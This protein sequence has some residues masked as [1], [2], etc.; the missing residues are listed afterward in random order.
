[1]AA[2]L[3][4]S[5]RAQAPEIDLPRPGSVLVADVT[6][7][8]AMINGDQKR[9]LKVDERVRIGS[10]LT[11]GRRSMLTL[12]LSNGASVQLGPETEIELE[13]FG[14]A[15]FSSSVKFAE[16]KAEPT[17]SRT[18]I[19]LVRGDLTAT[20]KSLQVGKGS[21]FTLSTPAGDLR[22]GAGAFHAMV[23]MHDLGLGVA[24]LELQSGT[25]EFQVAGSNAFAAVPAGRKLAFA[26]EVEKN[27]VVKVGEMPK[28]TPKAA[29]KKE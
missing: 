9:S 26:L 20:V 29:E 27:G 8:A 10:T 23:R 18:R 12:A 17:L 21:S 2:A 11:T 19:K 22:T 7:D 13:E 14:Q 16:M 28:E 25:A 15:P 5:G 24:T 1:M 4:T 6:G 3:A